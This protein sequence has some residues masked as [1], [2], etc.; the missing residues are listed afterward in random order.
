[1]TYIVNL[2]QGITFQDGTAFNASAVVFS[3]DRAI[4]TDSAGATTGLIVGTQAP[5]IINGS[6]EFSAT[7]GK[8]ASTY[9]QSQVNAF[10][11]SNGVVVGANPY[12]V[13]FHLGY[14]DA[15]F[16]YLL[17]LSVCEIL[18][19][20]YVISHWTAPTDGHGYITGVTAG[21][22]D[23][24]MN[25]HM[26]GTG[27]YQL[28]SYDTTTGDVVLVANQQYWGSPS[29]MGVASVP[30][31]DINFVASDSARV[32]DLKSGASDISDISTSDIFAFLNKSAWQTSHTVV[33]LS[34]DIT[35]YGPNPE[36]NMY[37][38]AWNYKILNPDGS[39]ASFQPF[40]N[41]NFRLAMA[42]AINASD[43]LY[44]A[45]N[46]LGILANEVVPYG[47]HGYNASVPL[48]YNYN[49]TDS[50]G[51]LTI[52]AQ[53]LGF[54]SS[55][56][57]SVSIVYAIG[58]TVGQ[59]E[60]TELATN[61][62]NMNLGITI[63]VIPQ[64]E[65]QYVSGIVGGFTPMEAISFSLDY[66]DATDYLSSFS[67]ALDI[68]LFVSYNNTAYLNL[69][70]EQAATTNATLRLQLIS[71]AELLLNQD[72]GYVFLYYPSVFGE[73][74]QM[75]RSWISGFV[76]NAAFPGPDFYQMSKA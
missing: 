68:G 40:R 47:M 23:M 51:N 62:N 29:G 25:T 44:N 66:A 49:L 9:N 60:A 73:T 13:I 26:S 34:S 53:A 21:E 30:E 43:I 52:A 4:L 35:V 17:P 69:V 41:K 3:I 72:V 65:N 19:P 36:L 8:G 12:Q 55:N 37:Y 61:I 39:V 75:F 76:F 38:I 56:P 2:R 11:N 70:N 71:Q 10:I 31:V 16:P 28:K 58:D 46:G 57:Q 45:A 1:M 32:L 54:N 59:A 74:G 20:S 18:S 5:G 22:E 67:S 14:A 7:Y 64:T 15:S 42:D 63:N 33:P 24:Y 48:Y 50:M 6:Y 27:P